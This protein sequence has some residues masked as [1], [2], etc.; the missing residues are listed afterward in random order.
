LKQLRTQGR[1]LALDD[2]EDDNFVE[3]SREPLRRVLDG[4]LG[5]KVREAVLSLPALQREALVLFE[6]E[7]LALSEIADLVGAD[8]GAVKARLHR[9]RG[10]LRSQLEPYFGAGS[11]VVSLEKA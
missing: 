4:E 8:V 1:E 2:F 10:R 9:A 3:A 7:G 5:S 6:Y 11:E